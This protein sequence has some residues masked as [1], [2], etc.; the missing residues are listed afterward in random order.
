MATSSASEAGDTLKSKTQQSPL[1]S[2]RDKAQADNP[3]KATRT[4]R[5]TQYFPL[6]YKDGF[7]QWVCTITVPFAVLGGRQEYGDEIIR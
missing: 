5:F 4:N 1:A 6:G 7:S 2:Q 3:T